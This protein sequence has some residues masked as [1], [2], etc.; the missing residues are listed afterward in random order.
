MHQPLSFSLVLPL[1]FSHP[2]L[3]A[4][5]LQGGGCRQPKAQVELSQVFF[6]PG[7]GD[8]EGGGGEAASKQE[9]SWCADW[10]GFQET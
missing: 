9:G 2:Q 8:G 6:H 4:R 5:G 7:S 3:Q 10:T 1:L